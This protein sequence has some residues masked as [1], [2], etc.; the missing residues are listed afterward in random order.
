MSTI[1]LCNRDLNSATIQQ[2]CNLD[3]QKFSAPH[4]PNPK[5]VRA[6]T[7]YLLNGHSDPQGRRMQALIAPAHIAR[8]ITELTLTFGE[9]NTLALAA[10][11]EQ[12]KDYNVAMTGASTSVY[13]ERINGF[14]D[15]VKRYQRALLAYR[16]AKIAKA[17][18]QT[19]LKQ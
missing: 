16:D 13:G 3:L 5:S 9:D 11:M 17:A 8:P 4:C 6:N 15:S 1:L 7:P 10:M 2:T 19:Q 12:L 18:S 14:T